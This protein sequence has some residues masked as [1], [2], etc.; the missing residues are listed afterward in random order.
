MYNFMGQNYGLYDTIPNPTAPAPYAN[1]PAHSFQ[2]TAQH[3]YQPTK[4]IQAGPVGSHP[5]AP[6]GQN[7]IA[8]QQAAQA[9]FEQNQRLAEALRAQQAQAQQEEQAAQ[10]NS[11]DGGWY[12]G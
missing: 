7:F 5:G 2:P 12:N 1:A 4:P 11:W 10:Q 9:Q 8:Q 6:Q 3:S